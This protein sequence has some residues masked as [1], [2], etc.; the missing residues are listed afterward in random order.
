[1]DVD[2]VDP[3]D[4]F[5]VGVSAEVDEL[6]RQDSHRMQ[7]ITTEESSASRGMQADANGGLLDD[8]EEEIEEE[9]E[10]ILA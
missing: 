3:L 10:D 6:S 1:M 9:P 7:G 5:M 8:G 4:A 2:E